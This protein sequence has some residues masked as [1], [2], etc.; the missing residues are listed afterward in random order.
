[1]KGE[2]VYR[3]EV[4]GSGLRGA[5]PEE[6]ESLLNDVAAEGWDL[7]SISHQANSNR[8]WVVLWSNAGRDDKRPARR[9]GWNLNWG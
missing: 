6:L 3:V 7:H 9:R 1:V 8:V 2:T 4:L 5:R